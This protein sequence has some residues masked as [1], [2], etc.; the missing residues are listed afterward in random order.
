MTAFSSTREIGRGL[1]VL[2]LVWMLAVSGCGAKNTSPVTGKVTFADGKPLAKGTVVFDDGEHVSKANIQSDGSYRLDY[3]GSGDGA[4]PGSYD[5]Y[6]IGAAE[7]ESG[8][9]NAKLLIDEKY[10]GAK[11]SGLKFEVKDGQA[12]V[13]DIQVSAPAK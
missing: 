2:C 12:N 3:H 13:F 10:T 7:Y 8:S 5:V 11:K 4:P 9:S 6:I 1:V